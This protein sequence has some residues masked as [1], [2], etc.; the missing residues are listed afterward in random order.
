MP[1]PLKPFIIAFPKLLPASIALLNKLSKFFIGL[2]ILSFITAPN[3]FNFEPILK[4][5]DKISPA[6]VPIP[7]KTLPM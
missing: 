4:M 5:N 7:S 1:N 3:P 2:T 6:V